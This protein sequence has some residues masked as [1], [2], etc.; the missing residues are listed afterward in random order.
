[1]KTH[2]CFLVPFCSGK[3]RLYEGM[4]FFFK[5]SVFLPFL[6]MGNP[7][8]QVLKKNFFFGFFDFFCLGPPLPPKI[9]FFEKSPIKSK[10]V[11]IA[12]PYLKM[13]KKRKFFWFV[14]QKIILRRFFTS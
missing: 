3:W 10:I 4:S 1:M 14:H 13:M 9:D 7:K 8:K 5:S 2:T 11:L 6:A 12:L